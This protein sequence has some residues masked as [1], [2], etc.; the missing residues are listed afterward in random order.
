MATHYFVWYR[1]PGD[2][3]TARG[4][5]NTLMHDIARQTGVIG[6]LLLRPEVPPTWME[7]YEC[8]ADAASFDVAYMEAVA[9]SGVVAHAPEGRHIE[10][11]V[12]AP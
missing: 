6:R 7:V 9:N 10:R 8:V 11:F 5:V 1:V 12:D 2:P 4:A 3:A